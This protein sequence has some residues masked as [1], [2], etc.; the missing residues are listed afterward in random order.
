MEAITMRDIR[1]RIIR[2]D[3]R[4]IAKKEINRERRIAKKAEERRQALEVQRQDEARL[5]Q[6]EAR[7]RQAAEQ[8]IETLIRTLYNQGVAV[9]SIAQTVDM[10]VAS[11]QNIIDK[12]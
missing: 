5:R 10:S 11:I 2:E 1:D 3:E 6:D 12:K 9:E 7:L 8:K 4:R